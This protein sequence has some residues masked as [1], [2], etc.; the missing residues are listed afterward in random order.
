MKYERELHWGMHFCNPRMAKAIIKVEMYINE[1]KEKRTNLSVHTNIHTKYYMTEQGQIFKFDKKRFV[2][3][4]LDQQEMAWFRNQDFVELYV[5]G[6][7]RCTEMD[8]F[9]DYF[10]LR[11]ECL[12]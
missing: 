8:L 1:L 4:E 9:E 11:R 12:V 3:Y 5:D 10:G 7:L 2:S 6:D